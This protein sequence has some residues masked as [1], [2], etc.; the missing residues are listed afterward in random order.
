MK[1][2]ETVVVVNSDGKFEWHF[3][4]DYIQQLRAEAV[5]I[6][7]VD[8]IHRAALVHANEERKAQIKRILQANAEELAQII[9]DYNNEIER[10]RNAIQPKTSE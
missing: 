1:D 3:E 8:T 2:N 4:P 6:Q 9:R 7:T 10:W 5:A